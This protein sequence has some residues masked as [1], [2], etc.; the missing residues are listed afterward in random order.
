[1]WIDEYHIQIVNTMNKLD[2]QHDREFIKQQFSNKVPQEIMTIF[3][4]I[5]QDI[6]AE[7]EEEIIN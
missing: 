7:D 1:M 5:G 3:G 4:Q 2:R 6:E